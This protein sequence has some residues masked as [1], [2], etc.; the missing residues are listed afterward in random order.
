MNNEKW[1]VQKAMP[2]ADV[3]TVMDRSAVIERKFAEAD[4]NKALYSIAI[5]FTQ[6]YQGDFAWMLDI[7]QRLEQYG[8][9]F[10]KQAAGA[11]NTMVRAITDELQQGARQEKRKI[12]GPAASAVPSRPTAPQVAGAIQQ[13]AIPDGVYEMRGT[14]GQ[15]FHAVVRAGRV[16]MNTR[17]AGEK[18]KGMKVSLAVPVHEDGLFSDADMAQVAQGE[19]VNG[20]PRDKSTYYQRY[21]SRLEDLA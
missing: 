9:L 20:K 15:V 4:I 18:R 2:A 16:S 11:L 12:M 17:P 1:S 3:A 7:Q 19:M 8:R 21:D 5:R 10:D 13:E 6:A 14:D